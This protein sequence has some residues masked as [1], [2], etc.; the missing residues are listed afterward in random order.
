MTLSEL[1]TGVGIVVGTITIIKG[2]QAGWSWYKKRRI[3][4]PPF[5]R[6]ML[7]AIERMELKINANESRSIAAGDALQ[8]LE[9]N[10]VK[11]DEY[12]SAML[13]ERLESAYTIY[14]LQMGWCPSGEK[15]MLMDLFELHEARG[16][17]HINKKYKEA[18]ANLPEHESERRKNNEQAH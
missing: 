4:N 2:V 17:N 18:I 9:A 10:V 8:R 16:W 6:R 1:G 13:R 7:N 12:F 5:R 11:T 14:V 15:R 3:A